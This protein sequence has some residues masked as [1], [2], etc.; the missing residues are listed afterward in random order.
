MKKLIWTLV[1]L[2]V[3]GVFGGRAWWLYT[4][5]QSENTNE[6]IIKIGAILPLTSIIAHEGQT[7]LES[8]KIAE[9]NINAN[10]EYGFIVKLI[11]ED[12]KYT[13]KDSLNAFQ[14]LMTNHIDA[15]IVLGE[16]PL[17][18]ITKFV[19]ENKVPTLAIAGRTNLNTLSP[20]FFKVP[21]STTAL[22]SAFGKYAVKE[23]GLKNIGVLYV[24][25]DNGKDPA[26]AFIEAARKENAN[27]TAEEKY[28]QDEIDTKS[29]VIKIVNTDPDAILII[30]FGDKSFPSSINY[31]REL[32][33][34]KPILSYFSI[35]PVLDKLKDK[36][37]I[38][39]VDVLLQNNTETTAYKQQ[40]AEKFPGLEPDWTPTFGYIAENMIAKVASKIGVEEPNSFMKELK[41][42]LYFD[43][44]YGKLEIIGE[45][46]YVPLYVKKVLPNGTIELVNLIDSKE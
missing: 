44:P 20:Y 7:T 3:V 29:Q 39:F 21:M 36:S 23:M 41:S 1:I 4:Q 25:M 8:L 38:Y 37:N 28:K 10:P 19:N 33:Y 13:P 31:I 2:V 24:D 14:K 35:P 22:T 9:K 16:R 15:L 43:T 40:F 6:K 42:T 32:G 17:N 27:I 34:N 45:E 5:K 30:G 12:G 46:T 11:V 26:M 18:A